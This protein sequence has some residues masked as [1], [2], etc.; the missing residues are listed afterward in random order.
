MGKTTLHGGHDA[1]DEEGCCRQACHEEND[2]EH[3]K[4]EGHEEVNGLVPLAASAF[5]LHDKFEAGLY[6]RSVY[7]RGGYK[8][9]E[10]RRMKTTEKRVMVIVTMRMTMMRVAMTV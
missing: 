10:R 1:H 5:T 2:E 7:L 9:A 8:K 6:L 3:E 4:D